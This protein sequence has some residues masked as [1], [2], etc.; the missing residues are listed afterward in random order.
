MLLINGFV[1]AL[2]FI[3]KAA[4]TIVAAYLIS[5]MAATK[6]KKTLFIVELMESK[7][8]HFGLGF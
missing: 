8:C 2:P 1:A 5:W 6:S 4:T 7:I 3:A